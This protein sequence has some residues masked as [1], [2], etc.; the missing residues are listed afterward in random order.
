MRYQTISSWEKHLEQASP[1]HLCPYYF[2]LVED[3]QERRQLVK[4]AASFFSS[5]P[6]CL[7]MDLPWETLF[8]QLSSPTF[9]E[10]EGALVV[11]DYSRAP[12]KEELKRLKQFLLTS[13]SCR[14]ILGFPTAEKLGN[15]FEEKG[16]ILEVAKNQSFGQ[17]QQKIQERVAQEKKQFTKE[18]FRYLLQ[19]GKRT[20]SF[21]ENELE[22]LLCFVGDKKVIEK[23]DVECSLAQEEK[24]LW[25]L[26]FQMVWKQKVP[27][28]IFSMEEALFFPLLAFL[29]KELTLGWR[30]ALCL[31]QNIPPSA[32]SFPKLWGKQGEE[33]KQKAI[34]W[35]ENYFKKAL[36]GLFEVEFLAKDGINSYSS[37]LVL[38]IAE[39]HEH[40]P[41]S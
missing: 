24:A 17:W 26:S 37:L 16:V 32:P 38:W 25:Q 20:F 35:K 7:E 36:K 9:F 8:Y 30:L 11:A 28:E 10:P 33:K 5:G 6:L 2:L 15:W 22:K 12:S 4:K 29:R 34:V 41:S 27:K 21:W 14:L 3:D 19:G 40:T 18:A 1:D 23:K 39:L 13:P 31:R